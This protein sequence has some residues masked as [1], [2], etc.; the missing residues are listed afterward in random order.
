MHRARDMDSLNT[1]VNWIGHTLSIS[2]LLGALLG[3]FPAAASLV[4]LIFYLFQIYENK[5]FQGWLSARRQK[6]I[7]V[8]KAKLLVLMAVDPNDKHE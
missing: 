8:L 4:A 7:A 2:A 5:T 6:K 3:V 1:F